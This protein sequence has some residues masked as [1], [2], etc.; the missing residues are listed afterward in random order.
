MQSGLFVALSHAYKVS[1][2]LDG[3]YDGSHVDLVFG[4]TASYTS[5]LNDDCLNLWIFILHN[6]IPKGYSINLMASI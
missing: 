6:R 5:L 1:I 4:K 3:S 2:Y